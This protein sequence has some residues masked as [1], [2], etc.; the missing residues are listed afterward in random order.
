MGVFRIAR[1]ET[2]EY[3]SSRAHQAAPCRRTKVPGQCQD[4]EPAQ[5]PDGQPVQRER[6]TR[7]TEH[8]SKENDDW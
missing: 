3:E 2:G 4:A 5:R 1:V 6:Q 8:Q 7:W